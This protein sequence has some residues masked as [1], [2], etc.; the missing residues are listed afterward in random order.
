MQQLGLFRNRSPARVSRDSQELVRFYADHQ[1]KQHAPL[2]VRIPANFFNF[3]PCDR[4]PLAA[5]LTR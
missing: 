2:L 4:T 5:Y 3:Q 1:I